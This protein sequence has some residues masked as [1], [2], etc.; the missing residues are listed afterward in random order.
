MSAVLLLIAAPP[1]AR[2]GPVAVGPPSAVPDLGAQAPASRLA[3]VTE[4]ARSPSR[5]WLAAAS[6]REA[7]PL[8]PGGLPLLA[9]NGQSVA[10]ALFGATANSENGPAIAVYSTLGAPV[11]NYLDLATATST[12]LAWSPDSRYLAVARQSTA[13]TNIAAG[14]GLDVIDTQTGIVTSV[15][16]GASYGAS[17]ARD[18]SDRL[19]F[20]L[21]HSLSSS[22][23]VNLYL[24]RPDGSGLRRLTGDGRSLNPVWGPR[25]IAYDRERPRRGDAPVFQIWLYRP[26]AASAASAASGAPAR[27]LTNVHVQPLVSGLVPVAFSATGARLLAEFE[28]ED[29]SEAWT[30]LVPSARARRLVVRGRPVMAAGISRDGRTLLIDEGSFE[31]PPSNGRVASI[32]FAGGRPQVLVAHGSQGAWNA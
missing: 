31:D 4:T 14:S 16:E 3:Y 1:A 28:G 5:V 15:A 20:A 25:Y 23:P 6:G 12:P 30:V 2:A 10:A 9:P 8:G 22:A 18:G 26:P 11:A 17:F 19:A 21:S 29:T 7:K 32:P 27:R 13:V 24:S